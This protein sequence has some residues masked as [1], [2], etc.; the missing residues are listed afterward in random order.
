ME[1]SDKH[2]AGDED[3]SLG[4]SYFGM[5]IQTELIPLNDAL[6]KLGW[7][8]DQKVVE[9]LLNGS[10]NPAELLAELQAAGMDAARAAEAIRKWQR[11]V[12]AAQ[13]ERERLR[14]EEEERKRKALQDKLDA[15]ERERI[16]NRVPL[17]RCGVCGRTSFRW[18]PC[19]VAPYFWKYVD[20]RDF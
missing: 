7:E 11:A 9:M 10:K 18:V 12:K 6:R 1:G 2:E 17:Y 3:S 16:K 13:E 4:S 15:K 8:H 14:R 5:D 19:P 20:K